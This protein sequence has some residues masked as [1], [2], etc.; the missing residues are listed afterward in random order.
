MYQKFSL[1][2]ENIQGTHAKEIFSFFGRVS[3][4]DD[5]DQLEE[6]CDIYV[7]SKYTRS[8]KAGNYQFKLHMRINGEPVS[9][10]DP[11]LR[12]KALSILRNKNCLI[13]DMKTGIEWLAPSY[14]S[15]TGFAPGV[16]DFVHVQVER[17]SERKTVLTAQYGRN[18]LSK[19]STSPVK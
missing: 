3:D 15:W 19:D 5:E 4:F 14:F 1:A 12:E 7:G 8:P 18:N 17:L 13:Y 6:P 9:S 10:Y 11:R 16:D 2:I